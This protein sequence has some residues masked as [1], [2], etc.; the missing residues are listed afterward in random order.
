MSAERTGIEAANAPADSISPRKYNVIAQ[1]RGIAS[2][3]VIGYVQRGATGW[4]YFPLY[5]AD[6]SR[7]FW[8]TPDAALKGRV[9]T[10]SLEVVA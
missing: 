10:Y 6:A 4:R 7:K 5:Q 1:P 8:P 3:M 9:K 2:P